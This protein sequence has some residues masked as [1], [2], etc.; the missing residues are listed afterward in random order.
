[1]AVVRRP[2]GAE[3]DLVDI[4]IYIAADNPHAA[5][6]IL[7][8]IDCKRILLAGNPRLGRARPEDRPR[9][10]LS[11]DRQLSHPKSRTRG[12]HRGRPR[13]PRR[14]AIGRPFGTRGGAQKTP[15][16]R[17][18]PWSVPDITCP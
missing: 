7:E 12:R 2:A 14:Q 4:W 1:M 11:A 5:D 15:C 3:E 10:S 13:R 17:V 16:R 8:K 9:A 18:L 6:L